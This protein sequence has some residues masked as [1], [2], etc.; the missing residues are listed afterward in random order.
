MKRLIQKLCNVFGYT[1]SKHSKKTGNTTDIVTV[2]PEVSVSEKAMIT[3]ALQYSMTN[4]ERMWA[5][6]QAMKRIAGKKIDGDVVECGVWKGGNILL[7]SL[8]LESYGLT[9]DVWA[10]D[11]YE[12][13][14]EPTDNDVDFRGTHSRLLLEKSSKIVSGD[15][16]NVW[17][18]STLDEVRENIRRNTKNVDSIHFVKGKVEDTLTDEKNLPEKISLLRIDTDWYESTKKSLEVLYPR[19]VPGGVLILDDYGHWKG[20]RKAFDEYFASREETPILHRV[21]Y[22]CRVMVKE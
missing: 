21:D 7:F 5:I 22:T 6:V 12:G 20:S 9:K 11:T 1:I 10:Y 4:P 19:L 17:C 2:I 16:H 8:L 15:T 3:T 18:Y 13:M 14:S